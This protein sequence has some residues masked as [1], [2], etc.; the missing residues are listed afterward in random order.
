[1]RLLRYIVIVLL[2]AAV[3]FPLY[4]M[5][6]SSVKSFGELFSARP[7]FWPS[8]WS[9]A[10]FSEVLFRHRFLL[11]IRNSLFVSS[12]TVFFTLILSTFGAYGLS[13]LRFPGRG[14]FSGALLAS[15]LFP[16]VLLVIP[17]FVLLSYLGLRNRFSGLIVTYIAQT[18]PVAVLM[19]S[20]Y[21]RAIPKEVEEAGL[22]D[23]CSRLGI[24]WRLFLP[25]GAP[26]L[27][28][29][30]LYV[31]VIAWNEFLFAYVFFVDPRMFTIPIGIV[32][33]YESY[34][35]SWNNVMAASLIS[36]VPVLIIFASFERYFLRGLA[37]GAV[38]G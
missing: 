11:Y 15:Y 8:R 17:L 34:H 4:W 26:A 25:M 31:F 6:I 21:F 37:E 5:A 10:S 3:V 29:V 13:R 28:T 1:M 27:L 33:L 14:V 18:L 35:T 2:I 19:L 9:L 7:V 20:N 30:G 32:H 23:G 38:K 36:S 24:L 12:L 16:A 22:L